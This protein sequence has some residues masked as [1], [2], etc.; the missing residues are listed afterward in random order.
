M[1]H[2]HSVGLGPTGTGEQ[3]ARQYYVLF[4]FIAA[5]D[6]DPQRMA[7]GLTSYSV[8]TEYGLLDILFAPFLLP[9]TITTRTVTVR[10]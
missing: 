2:Q 7:A 10:T 3:V 8:E 1:A 5:N 4:G 9:L 6:V